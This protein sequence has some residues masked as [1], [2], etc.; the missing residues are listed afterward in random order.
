MSTII[1]KNIV[2]II[3]QFM[4]NSLVV[5]PLVHFEL[6]LYLIGVRA[7]YFGGG[8]TEFARMTWRH[9][10]RDVIIK[11]Y[12]LRRLQMKGFPLKALKVDIKRNILSLAI[13]II[14]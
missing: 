11:L 14:S 7:H 13:S 9:R 3:M 2:L 8:W 1:N 4:H 5:L 6:L 10:F 12:N